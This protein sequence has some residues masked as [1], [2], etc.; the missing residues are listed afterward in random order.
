MSATIHKCPAT[1]P[2]TNAMTS[3][4]NMPNGGNAESAN[5][6]MHMSTAVT[7]ATWI[8]PLILLKSRVPY[9]ISRLPE[10]QNMSALVRP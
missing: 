1:T 3:E 8:A 4:M 10:R 7:G 9:L 5:S 2:E 6:P